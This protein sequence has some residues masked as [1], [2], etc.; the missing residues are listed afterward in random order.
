[1][2]LSIKPAQPVPQGEYMGAEQTEFFRNLLMV[3]KTALGERI[4]AHVKGMQSQER[5]SD[6]LDKAAIE[7]EQTVSL[8]LLDRLR[9][10]LEQIKQAIKRL[11][12]G[13]YGYCESTGLE[14]GVERLLLN[15]AAS[16]SFEA[17]QY[18]E[19]H[20]KHLRRA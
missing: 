15:P 16:L 20:E 4:D 14:I 5:V 2:M 8:K 13:D 7:Y 10:D 9:K 17:M 3:Q 11:D 18:R 1:M 6:E 19:N 12:A